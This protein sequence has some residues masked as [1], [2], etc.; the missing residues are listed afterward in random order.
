M[1][2]EVLAA[3]AGIAVAIGGLTKAI[4]ENTN[5]H[6]DMV[7]ELRAI[8]EDT[9]GIEAMKCRYKGRA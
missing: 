3:V 7:E 6:R 2:G 5:I 1:W 9:E 8:R 4:V